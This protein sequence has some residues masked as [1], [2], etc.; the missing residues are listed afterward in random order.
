M[1]FAPQEIG[2][3]LLDALETSV[4]A[5]LMLEII[6]LR[7]IP[8]LPVLYKRYKDA[9]SKIDQSSTPWFEK[10]PGKH[11]DFIIFDEIEE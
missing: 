2:S 4:H 1:L 11:P 3:P 10:D 9:I 6:R 8:G 7:S 5:A